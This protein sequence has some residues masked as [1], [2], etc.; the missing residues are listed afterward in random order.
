MGFLKRLG[1]GIAT[2][3]LS[4]ILGEDTMS[5][6]PVLNTLSGAK[7]NEQKELER[8]QQEMATQ[9]QKR[10]AVNQRARL[11]ALGQKM[12]AFNP[13]NQ[14][15][16]QMFG[17]QAAFSP[18]QMAQ[19]TADP[20][21][22]SQQQ[23]DEETNAALMRGSINPRTRQREMSEQDRVRLVEEQRR[24][25]EDA[26]RQQRV[27]GQMAPVGPGPAP[28]QPRAPQAGRRY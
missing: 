14:M 20:F 11:Q 18:E 24:R 16:A 3:G 5:G 22:M 1:L 13:Q 12:L 6:V 26:A 4:E 8:R 27:Q 7:S 10:A 15:M 21:A 25:V 28:L 19:M 17:P 23:F 2:G 9:L